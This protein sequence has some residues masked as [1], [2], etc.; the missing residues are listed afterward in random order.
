MN[1]AN[2]YFSGHPKHAYPQ[3][4]GSDS[5]K[6]EKSVAALLLIVTFGSWVTIHIEIVEEII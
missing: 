6:Y 2:E 3:D 4:H 5:C 1:F